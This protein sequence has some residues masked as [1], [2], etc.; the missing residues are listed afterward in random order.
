MSKVHVEI[1]G[2]STPVC[3]L[4]CT[5]VEYCKANGIDYSYMDMAKG[6][7]D[8][9]VLM[10][11]RGVSIRTLPALFV[12]GKFVVRGVSGLKEAVIASEVDDDIADELVGSTLGSL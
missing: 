11:E 1:F 9:E 8:P 5:A 4:C 7:W 3:S 6:E 2:R 10:S 12:N